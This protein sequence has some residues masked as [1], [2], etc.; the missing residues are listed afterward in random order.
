MIEGLWIEM[1]SDKLKA[2]FEKRVAY[3]VAK[4]QWYK[5]QADSI[6]IGESSL[7]TVASNNP[8][9]SLRSSQKNHEDKAAFFTVLAENIIPNET[10]RLNEQN[11]MRIE[12]YAQYF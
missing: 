7:G 3:H 12:L 6:E 8:V 9:Q 1:S 10:Y 2:L 4:R 5:A 11:C